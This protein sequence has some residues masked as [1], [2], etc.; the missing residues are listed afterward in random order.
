[1]DDLGIDFF[2]FRFL[3]FG[4]LF[5]A[6]KSLGFSDD[7]DNHADLQHHAEYVGPLRVY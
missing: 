1:M 7:F 6:D 3:N 5:G 4:F 2:E